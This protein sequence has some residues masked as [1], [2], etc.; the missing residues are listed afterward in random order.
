[1]TYTKE[2]LERALAIE[3]GTVEQ[4]AQLIADVR[5]EERE[6]CL[7]AYEETP[8]SEYDAEQMHDGVEYVCRVEWDH[9]YERLRGE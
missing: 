5:R 6:R 9:L 2:D 3:G 1:M 8:I 4:T 7:E